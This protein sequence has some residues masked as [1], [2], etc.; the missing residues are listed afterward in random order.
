M[1]T[2]SALGDSLATGYN[3]CIVFFKYIFGYSLKC[4]F[5]LNIMAKNIS[6]LAAVK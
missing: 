3:I 5:V 2:P 1:S 4:I 6:T